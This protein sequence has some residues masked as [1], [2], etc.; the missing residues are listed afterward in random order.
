MK[1]SLG[2][3]EFCRI[4]DIKLYRLLCERIY[5]RIFDGKK[6]VAMYKEVVLDESILDLESWL[7]QSAIDEVVAL[8]L[9]LEETTQSVSSVKP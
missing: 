3:T 9:S 6:V 7:P 5:F 4:R 1:T 2:K 8:I